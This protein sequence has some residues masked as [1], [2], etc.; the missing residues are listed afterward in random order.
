[1]ADVERIYEQYFQDVYLFALSLS[2]DQQIAEEI[3]QETFAKAV[4]NID[5]FKGNCKISVWLCQIAKNTYFKYM[6]KQK[7]YLLGDLQEN[8]GG[9]TPSIEQKL[10]EKTEALRIH[11]LL[12]NLKEPYKEV[13]MLRVFGE[14]SF[15][16]I[17][18]VFGRTESWARV[19]FHRAR[20]SIQDL[21][22][23]EKR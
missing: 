21:M 16:Q 2:R 23:E 20:N 12:H 1:M 5:Q 18:E 8:T 3:T 7:H 4:K 13:F 19:T 14:L 9:N 17:S 11:K 6:D 15:G 10:I 22:T